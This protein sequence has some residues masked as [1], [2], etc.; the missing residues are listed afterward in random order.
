MDVTPKT[1]ILCGAAIDD[2]D[3]LAAQMTNKDFIICA[4]SGLR[5]AHA[6][7]RTPDII[8]GDFDS[9]DPKLLDQYRNKCEVIEDNDQNATDLMKALGQA[10]SNSLIQIYGAI[11]ERADHDF[12]NYLILKSLDHPDHITIC[13]PNETR[14]IITKPCSI[15]GHIGDYVGIFPLSDVH[16]LATEGLKYQP[17]ILGG[18]YTFGWNGA[19]N[20]MIADT[21]LISL[22]KG[23]ILITHSHINK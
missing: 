19:C 16:D 18:P 14:R 15:H 2:Y 22:S 9:V 23:M 17:D 10:P 21:A 13:S 11:G 12:S 1:V 5:H 4:D 3:W 8:I 6:I 7:N 20:E